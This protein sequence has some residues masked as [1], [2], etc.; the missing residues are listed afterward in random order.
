VFSRV[1]FLFVLTN[2]IPFLVKIMYLNNKS[3]LK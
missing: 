1:P 2:F 3:F